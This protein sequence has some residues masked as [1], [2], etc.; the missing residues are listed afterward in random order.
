M[1]WRICSSAASPTIAEKSFGMRI[2]TDIGMP[3]SPKLHLKKESCRRSRSNLARWEPSIRQ[4]ASFVWW[5]SIISAVGWWKHIRGL[6]C[7]HPHA[8]F[9]CHMSAN[10]SAPKNF[11]FPNIS[12]D[13]GNRNSYPRSKKRTYPVAGLGSQPSVDRNWP[14]DFLLRTSQSL[15]FFFFFCPTRVLSLSAR[16]EWFKPWFFQFSCVP[17]VLDGF[18]DFVSLF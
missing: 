14:C 7:R 9:H 5:K 6:A 4:L 16:S 11:R 8:T 17:C 12:S 2:G 15:A 1:T 10:R 3:F 18:S 13:L